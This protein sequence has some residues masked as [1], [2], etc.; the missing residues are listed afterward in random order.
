VGWFGPGKEP[1]CR[2][3]PNFCRAIGSGGDSAELRLARA[4]SLVAIG[5]LKDAVADYDHVLADPDGIAAHPEAY[6]LR[7]DLHCRLGEADSA[8]VG[9]QVW[10]ASAEGGT[11]R[12]QNMLWA[13]G[14]L[15]GP[16][17]AEFSPA[18]LAALRAWTHDGCPEA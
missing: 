4:E 12:G 17:A 11:D 7:A 2:R 8:A 6:R 9:W 14:Y 18:A 1:I 16:M 3:A 15:R 13:V 5:R 10:L